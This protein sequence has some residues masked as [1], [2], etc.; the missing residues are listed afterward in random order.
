[1]KSNSDYGDGV[2][3]RYYLTQLWFDED[4]SESW[5]DVGKNEVSLAVMKGLFQ[6]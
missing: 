3:I 5:Q 1:M 2:K 6:R 4:M